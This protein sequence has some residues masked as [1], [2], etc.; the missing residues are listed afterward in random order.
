MTRVTR[1]IVGQIFAVTILATIVL[2]LAT[3]LVQSV[4]LVDLIVTRGVPVSDFLYMSLLIIPR[5]LVFLLPITLF[6]ATVFTFNRMINDSELVVLR[7]AGL[8]SARLARAPLIA[9]LACMVVAYTLTLYLS[10]LASQ[11][12][13]FFLT[14]SRS[15]FGSVLIREGS[16][17]DVGNG[18]TIYVKERT[19]AGELKGVFVHDARNPDKTI[20]IMADRG[21]LV[22]T[23]D[24]PRIIVADGNQQSYS[25]GK[26]HYLDF[27]R[28]TV[29]LGTDEGDSRQHWSQPE[30]RF[31]PDLFY[32]GDTQNDVSYRSSLLTEGHNRIVQPLMTIAFTLIAAVFMLRGGY[33]RHGQNRHIL[34]AVGVMMTVLMSNLIFTSLSKKAIVMAPML[35]VSV[36]LPIVICGFILLKPRHMR[37]KRSPNTRAVGE[38]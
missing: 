9:A 8:S 19:P 37:S 31:L 28:Y 3:V 25:D 30:E 18:I 22:E 26:F 33:S 4:R 7:A 5:Y 10:P 23:D 34:L 12:L 21:A 38:A 13:R 27:D 2:C 20:T 11:E 16:F 32:P 35:Y 17:S 36:I 24:G 1:Y 15:Q 14:K 29:E 6:G